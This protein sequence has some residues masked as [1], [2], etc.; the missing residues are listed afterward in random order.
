MGSLLAYENE[1]GITMV[2]SYIHEAQFSKTLIFPMN[3]N[4]LWQ[5]LYSCAITLRPL[6]RHI[7]AIV[8]LDL[9]FWISFGT[10][11][12][13]QLVSEALLMGLGGL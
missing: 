9:H 2:A 11:V 7:E 3:F 6:W 8:G 1:F 12:V 10:K 13:P 5:A 4:D